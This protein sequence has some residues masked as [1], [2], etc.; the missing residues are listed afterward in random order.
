MID[1]FTSCTSYGPRR[2]SPRTLPEMMLD[3][4]LVSFLFAA[5]S[6]NQI[7]IADSRNLVC[8]KA[9]K[10]VDKHEKMISAQ[11]GPHYGEG[12]IPWRKEDCF[13]NQ[14]QCYGIAMHIKCPWVEYIQK[15]NGCYFPGY[16]NSDVKAIE[17]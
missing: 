9:E 6:L 4:G 17:R 2:I 13:A 10:W 8:W 5:I 1:T 14:T 7:E 3:L 15:K 16:W 12:L 11:D